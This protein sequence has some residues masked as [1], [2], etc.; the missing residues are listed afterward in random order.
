MSEAKDNEDYWVARHRELAG[1]LA[2]VGDIGSSQADNL[3]KY[4]VKKRRIVAL[5]KRLGKLDANAA[6][7]VLA[8]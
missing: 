3:V 7:E 2:A 6:R 5:L 8:P 4:A 1:K